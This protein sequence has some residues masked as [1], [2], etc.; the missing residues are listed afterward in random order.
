MQV[1]LEERAATPAA[2]VVNGF[3]AQSPV[4]LEKYNQPNKCTANRTPYTSVF[5]VRAR[6]SAVSTQLFATGVCAAPLKL[7]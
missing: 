5:H 1:S 2:A 4:G 7:F 3:L 6:A